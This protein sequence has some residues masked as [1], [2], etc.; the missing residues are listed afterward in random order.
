MLLRAGGRVLL[1]SDRDPG[2]P[3]SQW[4]VL[5]GGG[6]DADEP[7]RTAAAREVAEET[8]LELDP[9]ALRGPVAHRLVTHGY[10]DRVLVQEEEIWLAD[11]QRFEPRPALLSAGEQLRLAGWEWF[12]ADEVRGLTV[13]PPQVADWLAWDGEPCLEMGE[14][15]ESTVPVEQGA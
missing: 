9:S 3:G 6:I 12:S 7:S 15:D 5:P 10:S 1:I 2:V 13:W 8:G 14:V 4:W 11:V